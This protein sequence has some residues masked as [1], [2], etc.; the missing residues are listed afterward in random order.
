MSWVWKRWRWCIVKEMVMTRRTISWWVGARSRWEKGRK[1]KRSKDEEK[2]W[3]FITM[4]DGNNWRKNNWKW[5]K[6]LCPSHLAVTEQLLTRCKVKNYN[7]DINYDDYNS[8]NDN[9][10]G[11]FITWCQQKG[12]TTRITIAGG[13]E[14]E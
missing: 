9:S 6:H 3:R 7:N 5:P 14:G 10:R 1:E 8:N 4:R 11:A 2:K 12:G 13:K